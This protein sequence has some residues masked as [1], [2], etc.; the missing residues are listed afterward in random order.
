M[1]I[2]TFEKWKSNK[3]LFSTYMNGEYHD[4]PVTFQKDRPNYA[5]LKKIALT[6]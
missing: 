4:K 1:K 6:A 3:L 2:G 5:R